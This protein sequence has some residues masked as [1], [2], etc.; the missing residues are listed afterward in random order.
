MKICGQY[1]T[2]DVISRIQATVDAE[3]GISRRAL[4]V[5]VCEWLN[6]KGLN[7]KLKEMSCRVALL[8]MQIKGILRLPDTEGRKLFISSGNI[9]DAAIPDIPALNCRLDDLAGVELVA[10]KTKDHEGS[11][12]WNALMNKYHYLGSGPLC[13]AQIRYFIISRLYGLLGGISFSAAAWRVGD[14]DRWIGWTDGARAANL[15]K[16]ICNSRFLIVPH[17]KVE[18]LASHVLSLAA[19]RIGED[20]FDRY[21]YKPLLLETYVERERFAGTCYRAANWQ[22]AGATTGRGRADR[23]RSCSVAI[24][25]VYLYP[26]ND[27]VKELLC[28]K[29]VKPD[30]EDSGKDWSEKE[31]GDA[32]FGDHRL[33]RRVVEIARDFFARPQANIPQACQ[34]RAKT[35]AA[36][37][38][39]EHTDTDMDRILEPHY[40][41]TLARINKETTVLAVQDTTS[42]NY[43]AHPATEELGPIGSSREGIIGL[44]VHDTMAFNLEGTPLGLMDVQCWSRDPADFGKKIRRHKVPIEQKESIKWLKSFERAARAQQRCPR[45][46]IVSVG[47][48]EA[49]IYELFESALKNPSNPKL[50][51]RAVHNRILEQEQGYLWDEM[52]KMKAIGVQEIEVP[53]QGNRPK[54]IAL[55]EV[56]FSRVTLKSPHRKS[57]I[58]KIDLRAILAREVEAPEGITPIEWRL[59]TT[60]EVDSFEQ[61]VEKLSWYSRRWGIEIYHR[62]LKSGCKIEERQLGHADRIESCLAIDMVV[63]WRIFYLARLGR[64]VPDVPCTVFFEDAEWKALLTYTKQDPVS[65]PEPPTLRETIRMVAVPGGFPGRK[66]DGEPGTKSLW[67]GL[68]RLDDMT[69]MW[70]VIMELLAPYLQN[71]SV[72]S[73][74]GYG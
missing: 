9:K 53:R 63:A 44:H 11:R 58:K 61:A 28:N 18:Y 6:W 65:P 69:V 19:K 34:S 26:L 57:R 46:T 8:K 10:V 35:K 71:I 30:N 27:N 41:S 49:D 3:P 50:L 45:T 17:V 13:G 56:C 60:C 66:C 43:S 54:R 67:L 5:K 4:S 20:W 37:R 36:Y 31:F 64:E 62:T 40:E 59:L 74:P 2:E 23:I 7:G 25:D 72:S 15:S 32:D 70:K 24:K 51:V 38:F 14:R 52:N 29:P 1:F 68:Q 73:N 21:G 48:R 12:L 47:D 33:T 16:V 55:L 39:F 22:Y 42:L